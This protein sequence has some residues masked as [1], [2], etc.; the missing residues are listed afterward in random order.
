MS[1][2]LISDAVRPGRKFDRKGLLD[3][4][5]ARWFENFVYNQIWEDP[6]V[7]LA[8][9]EL[10]G[11]SR[12][13]TIASGGCNVLNYLAAGPKSIVAVDLNR[14]HLALTRLKLAGVQHLP[15][16]DHFFRFFGEA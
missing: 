10:T 9:L 14:A 3:L 13:V 11:D 8:A 2:R 6:E 15:D 16:H 12:L 5:F 7:D 1:N 4:L